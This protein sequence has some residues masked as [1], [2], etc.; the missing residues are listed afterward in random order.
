L[1]HATKHF[2]SSG[3]PVIEGYDPPEG[4]GW[5]FVDHAMLDLGADTTP[6]DGPIPRYYWAAMTRWGSAIHWWGRSI[7]K[8]PQQHAL[9]RELMLLTGSA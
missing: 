7:L 2:R 5:C 1:R 8:Q 9:E 4:W 3:H 6:Q